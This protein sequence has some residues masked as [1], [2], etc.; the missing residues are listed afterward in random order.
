[1]STDIDSGDRAMPEGPETC[2]D[3]VGPR[4]WQTNSTG[5]E[6]TSRDR[7]RR[8]ATGAASGAKT[9][10]SARRPADRG[11]SSPDAENGPEFD[12]SAI[13]ARTAGVLTGV[14]IVITG[15]L[16]ALTGTTAATGALVGGPLQIEAT[17]EQID[18]TRAVLET[19]GS[20][21]V[22]RAAG[23]AVGVGFGLTVG[24]VGQFLRWER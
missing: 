20:L 16:L 17:T 8:D 23:V 14:S 9:T 24:A 15:V 12:R 1:M 7:A 3:D 10:P 2:G 13:V 4:H 19:A 21:N 22:I 18:Q 6:P 11:R 5:E